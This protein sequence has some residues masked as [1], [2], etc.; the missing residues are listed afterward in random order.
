MTKYTDFVFFTHT[1]AYRLEKEITACVIETCASN[2]RDW[3]A[4]AFWEIE[5]FKGEDNDDDLL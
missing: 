2:R 3:T 5:F 1:K 4:G